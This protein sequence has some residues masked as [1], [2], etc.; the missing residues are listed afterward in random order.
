MEVIQSKIGDFSWHT[1]AV[2]VLWLTRK[3]CIKNN[4]EVHGILWILEQ[5]TEK[6]LLSTTE[7]ILKLK[8]LMNIN[9]WLPITACE[10]LIVKWQ[11][12][13]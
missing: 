13:E 7:A 12:K 6:E 8:A 10:K 9:L 3:W 4:L 2:N 5:F 11:G 1:T